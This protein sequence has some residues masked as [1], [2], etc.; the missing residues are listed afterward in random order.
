MP[1][2][3]DIL[4]I[5]QLLHSFHSLFH[6]GVWASAGVMEHSNI[7]YLQHADHLWVCAIII[8]HHK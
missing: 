2:R 4:P 6:N 5:P 8:T 3:Q 7:S 1:R